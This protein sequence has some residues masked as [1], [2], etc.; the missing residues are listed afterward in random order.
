MKF[1]IKCLTSLHSLVLVLLCSTILSRNLQAAISQA[2]LDARSNKYDYLIGE[3][4]AIESDDADVERDLLADFPADMRIGHIV[5]TPTP[6]G[7]TKSHPGSAWS[8]MDLGLLKAQ[9]DLSTSK[10]GD[11]GLAIALAEFGLPVV[12]TVKPDTYPSLV[13][14]KQLPLLPLTLPIYSRLNSNSKAILQALQAGDVTG[15]CTTAGYDSLGASCIS[16]NGLCCPGQACIEGVCDVACVPACTGSDVCVGTTCVTPSACIADSD[17]SVAGLTSCD[18]TVSKCVI[19]GRVPLGNKAQLDIDCATG[20]RDPASQLCATKPCS[21]NAGCTVMGLKSCN[22]SSGA[23]VATGSVPSGSKAQLATDCVTGYLD[24]ASKLCAIK[25]AASCS[26]NAGCTVAGLKS[27]NISLGACVATGSVPSGS[28][29]QTVAD[30]VTGY[31]D[32]ASQLCASKEAVSCIS[33]TDCGGGSFCDLTTMF[34]VTG[35]NIPAGDGCTTLGV[36]GGCSTGTVCQQTN[37]GSGPAHICLAC[38]VNNPAGCT[39]N[40]NPVGCFSATECCSCNCDL[41]GDTPTYTC[42][43]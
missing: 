7:G 1:K 33:D 25:P 10:A 21:T 20:Y 30:C 13:K 34:C 19:T 38:T 39:V 9:N 26:T 37:I 40:D 32:P 23:C 42:V 8:P 16:N 36:T 31:I 24:A 29:A 2:A 12:Q 27:C 28:K 35:A 22:I 41:E 43:P 5:V 4:K 18:L 11:A 6:Y 3:I 14:N 15:V 17:C